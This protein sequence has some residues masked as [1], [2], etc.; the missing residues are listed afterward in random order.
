VTEKTPLTPDFCLHVV[1]DSTPFPSRFNPPT[2]PASTTTLFDLGVVDTFT[3]A[4]FVQDVK[5]RIRPWQINDT[6][7]ASSRDT[8]L[9]TAADSV[10]S[11]AF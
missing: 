3:A 6:D 2:T 11:N 8:T 5:S 9:Q 1:V 10:Q 7:I 4:T